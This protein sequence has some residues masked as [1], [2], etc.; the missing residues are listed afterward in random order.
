MATLIA[1][2]LCHDFISPTG[3]IVSGLELM[4]DPSAG[5]MRDEALNLIRASVTKLAAIVAF[6]RVAFGAST[7]A[8]SFST[9]E[10]KS[11]SDGMFAHMRGNLSWNIPDQVLGKPASRALLNLAYIAGTAL[12]MGGTAT[13]TLE[14]DD[15]A[16]IFSAHCAGNR[17]RLKAEALTGLKGESL[18]EGLT[19]QWIQPYWLWSIV[20]EAG[21]I[22]SFDVET[23]QVRFTMTLP[24]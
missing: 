6:A 11:L 17:A 7:T 4:D 3:A 10:L 2:K 5:D 24:K 15:N 18:Y 8:E 16:Q 9:T 23:D 20:N 22:L 19:G 12:P 13:L 1:A 21:G 14:N